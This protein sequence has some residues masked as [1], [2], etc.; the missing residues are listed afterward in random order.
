MLIHANIQIFTNTNTYFK[1]SNY[2]L[3]MG[4]QWNVL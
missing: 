4:S 2:N 1:I 3:S